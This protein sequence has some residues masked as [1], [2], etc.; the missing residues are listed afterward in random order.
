MDTFCILKSE[1]IFLFFRDNTTPTYSK[2][3]SLGL[4]FSSYGWDYL[5]PGVGSVQ[6]VKLLPGIPTQMRMH[7]VSV[8]QMESQLLSFRSDFLWLPLGRQQTMAEVLERGCCHTCGRPAWSCS[9]PGGHWLQ[10]RL[11]RWKIHIF[12]LSVSTC[13]SLPRRWK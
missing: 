5:D 2:Y 12:S 3:I 7:P 13:A 4:V 1:K 8:G 6:W 11:V 9:L 10:L